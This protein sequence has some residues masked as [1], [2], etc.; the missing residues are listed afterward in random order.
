VFLGRDLGTTK[1]YS[2]KVAEQIDAEVYKF[3]TQGYDRA[4]KILEENKDI[5]I[6]I[7]NYL[8]KHEVMDSE[9]FELC[10]TEGVTEEMLDEVTAR[11]KKVAEAES[12]NRKEELKKKKKKPSK[13]KSDE[14]EIFPENDAKT[15]EKNDNSDD[16]SDEGDIFSDD[17]LNH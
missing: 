4:L 1:N 15:D 3:V 11:K 17:I 16:G 2:E 5:M 9:Q 10:F 6:F 8:I 14:E 7:A 13:A 12:E